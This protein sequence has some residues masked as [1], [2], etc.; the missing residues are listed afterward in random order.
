[1]ESILLVRYVF[2]FYDIPTSFRGTNLALI[3]LTFTEVK[4]ENEHGFR[5]WQQSVS[6]TLLNTVLSLLYH[7]FMDTC[8]VTIKLAVWGCVRVV[9]VVVGLFACSSCCLT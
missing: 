4:G 3:F 9:V 8:K 7:L 1:M 6:G 2:H 5:F